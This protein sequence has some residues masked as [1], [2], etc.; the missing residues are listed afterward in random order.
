MLRYKNEVYRMT[1]KICS[2]LVVITILCLT[3]CS[4]KQDVKQEQNV[5]RVTDIAVDQEEKIPATV[6]ATPIPEPEEDGVKYYSAKGNEL[7]VDVSRCSP[8]VKIFNANDI[9]LKNIKGDLPDKLNDEKYIITDE[10]ALYK[11]RAGFEFDM[12]EFFGEEIEKESDLYL[13]ALE[14]WNF[15]YAQLIQGLDEMEKQCPISDYDY[16]IECYTVNSNGYLIQETSGLLVDKEEL[17]FLYTKGTGSGSSDMN[18]VTCDVASI[19]YYAALPKG[20]LLNDNYKKWK[21]L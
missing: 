2:L 1:K 19:C 11:F 12:L 5:T 3:A 4:E 6:T 20:T 10:E 15:A 9:Y 17:S 14:W 8:E 7:A 18:E 21:Y 16:V 13:E